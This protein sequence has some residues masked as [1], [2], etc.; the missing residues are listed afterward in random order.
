MQKHHRS[1]IAGAFFLLST[2]LLVLQRP[3]VVA[4][5]AGQ[6]RQQHGEQVKQGG[7][8][9]LAFDVLALLGTCTLYCSS[10]LPSP[11]L[12]LGSTTIKVR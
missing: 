8:H 2:W 3:L 10:L 4:Q 6:Q 12:G 1:S 7:E 9:V 11:S 5:Q